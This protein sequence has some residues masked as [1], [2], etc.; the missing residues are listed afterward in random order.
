MKL[1]IYI[2]QSNIGIH[3]HGNNEDK[4]NRVKKFC[5]VRRKRST[6]MMISA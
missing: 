2:Y 4:K 6:R 5:D 3:F 1:Q